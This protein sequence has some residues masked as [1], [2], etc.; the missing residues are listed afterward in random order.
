MS[1]RWF[2]AMIFA[3]LSP[4]S[5]NLADQNVPS[6][7]AVISESAP[8]PSIPDKARLGAYIVSVHD[9]NFSGETFS[10]DFWIWSD[11]SNPNLQILKTLEFV[12]AKSTL[13]NLQNIQEKEGKVWAQEKVQ[14]VFRH[15]WDMSN[16]PFD[17]H[18]LSIL[19]EEA[20]SDVEKLQYVV[21]E[22]NS[23]FGK[24]IEIAGFSI[25]KTTFESKE[26]D[27]DTNFGDPSAPPSSSYTQFRI[28][29]ELERVSRILF[30]KLHAALYVA[31]IVTAV[32]FFIIPQIHKT[33]QMINAVLSA[34]V[35]SIFATI[36]NLRAADSVIGRSESLTLV[37]RLHFMTLMYFT[38][39]GLVAIGVLITRER[40][41]IE[42]LRYFS[43]WAAAFYVLSYLVGNVI[44]VWQA[45]S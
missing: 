45:A 11:Y 28:N 2:L 16:F 18:V 26:R 5:T 24:D 27:Y 19:I 21:D 3:F 35:G 34:M 37:D 39:L 17:R 22:D 41:T 40:W 12:N 29:L 10:A 31:F 44:M 1:L 43:H 32:C 25:Q 4:V 13:V 14:G 15:H 6:P 8:A 33:P 7:S 42:Q 23:N 36:I 20:Q 9:L 30:L 38:L